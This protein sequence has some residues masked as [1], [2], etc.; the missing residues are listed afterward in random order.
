MPS[1]RCVTRDSLAGFPTLNY[2]LASVLSAMGF[3]QEAAEVLGETFE[4]KD[5]LIHTR[6][7]GRVDASDSSFVELLA[8]ERRA[9]MFQ[10]T[11]AGLTL[12]THVC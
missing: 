8:P 12:K 2:E 1:A 7:A 9:G 11:A 5:G 10:A 6:L 3:Y 4:I